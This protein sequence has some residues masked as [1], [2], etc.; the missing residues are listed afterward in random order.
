VENNFTEGYNW[1][2]ETIKSSKH[3]ALAHALEISKAL[4]FLKQGELTEAVEI[5]KSFEKKETKVATAAATNLSFMFFL[6]GDLEQAERYG[7]IAKSADFYNACAYVNL[8]NCM[9]ARG[10]YERAKEF[11][12]E[13]LATD[14]SC[15]E[16][17]YNLGLT[18]QHLQFYE[19]ALSCFH[20]VHSLCRSHPHV[21]FQLGRT[22]E[23]MGES[24]IAVE[25][26]LK[27]L[28]LVPTDPGILKKLGYMA[29]MEGDRQQAYQYYYD[30]YR[31]DP[32]DLEA[33]EWIGSYL[34]EV[35]LH[36]RAITFYNRATLLQP[37]DI[38]WPMLIAACHRRTGNYTQAIENYA[39]VYREN[40]D[41]LPSLQ[42]LA[43]LT[44]DMGLK[45]AEHYAEELKKL[46]KQ[47][48]NRNSA[49]RSAR[50]GPPSRLGTSRPGPSRGG[51]SEYDHD[52]GDN[53]S[54]PFTGRLDTAAERREMYG[55]SR[56]TTDNGNL[57]DENNY[58]S[59]FAPPEIRLR[60]A[61]SRAPSTA[62]RRGTEEDE[63]IFA[64]DDLSEDLLPF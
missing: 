53:E 22:H 42:A 6:Q 39:K 36:D 3:A 57:E 13:A 17:L 32:S 49:A 12:H 9:F 58:Q 56:G 33:I 38:R 55:M 51:S 64:N 15:T 50:F 14:S 2:T 48:E 16:A 44:A 20:K 54:I 4:V 25:W 8:G 45:E 28:A 18:N 40:P 52:R 37:S 43:R 29:E 31:H 7:D 27:A 41:H 5:L 47:L 62:T 21:T 26:Y 63:D 10:D 59:N 30:C 19:D 61:S 1:V 34:N 46:E 11:Y 24:D 35:Q 23:L 60:R